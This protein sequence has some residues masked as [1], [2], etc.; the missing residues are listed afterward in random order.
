MRSRTAPSSRARTR[1]HPSLWPNT[2]FTH[3]GLLQTP[4]PSSQGTDVPMPIERASS[5][6]GADEE[7]FVEAEV[8]E[9]SVGYSGF[10]RL[11]VHRLRHRRFDGRMSQLITREV[12]ERGD[13]VAVLPYDPRRDEVLFS[14]VSSCPEP[15]S[16]AACPDRCRSSPGWSGRGRAK[17][18]WPGGRQLRRRAV[19]SAVW[20]ELMRSCQRQAAAPS[21]WWCS[22]LKRICRRRAACMGWR[23]STRTSAS[24][25]SRLVRPFA[26]STKVLSRG[27]RPWSGWL[28]SPATTTE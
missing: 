10:F 3:C 28:G 12:L 15:I 14:S 18:R 22:A 5:G 24:K 21:A 17:R 23:R 26:F 9:T 8:L 27:G 19:E 2:C 7:A 16:A 13:A 25:S 1:N 4:D 20:N 6:L 11:D